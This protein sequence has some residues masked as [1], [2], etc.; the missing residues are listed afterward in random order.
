MSGEIIEMCKYMNILFE[1]TDLEQASPATVS[2][3]GMIYM[4]S[5]QLSWD[6]LHKS[7]LLK[8][9]EFGLNEI[10]MGLYESLVDWLVPAVLE[11]LEKCEKI[12]TISSTHK[13]KVCVMHCVC[14]YRARID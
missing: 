11:I 3:C 5:T 12:L 8:L 6:I 14:V 1:P 9:D 4:E 13:Y 10:Y 2:R 7:F